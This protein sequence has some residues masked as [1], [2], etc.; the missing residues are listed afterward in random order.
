MVLA[1]SLQQKRR[2]GVLTL[3]PICYDL[4]FTGGI[5]RLP[6]LGQEVFADT[7]HGSLGGGAGITAI[8]LARLGV[9][10]GIISKVGDD[11][12]GHLVLDNVRAEGVDVEHVRVIAGAHTDLSIAISLPSD[13]GFL[14]HVCA[15]RSADVM[16]IPLSYLQSARHLHICL[17]NHDEVA[18][19]A[20]LV[21]TAHLCDLTTSISLGWSDHWHQGLPDVLAM[22]NIV[23]PNVAEALRLC[24][25]RKLERACQLLGRHGATVVITRGAQGAIGWHHGQVI[26]IA[27]EPAEV[28][29]TTGAGD[30]F[31]AG[32]LWASL[33]GYALDQ[34][35][36]VANHCGACSV[37][38]YGSLTTP[39]TPAEL[40]AL[41]AS[42]PDIAHTSVTMDTAPH[43]H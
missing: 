16:D 8:T 12:F 32:F 34:C 40:H 20:W 14:S 18:R 1:A 10:T 25:T 26:D 15:N 23:F 33:Q 36:V 37:A 11:G 24:H 13:R 28:V 29:D 9:P 6:R 43:P 39:P 3:G 17:S 5:N 30:T 27:A 7:L 41:A 42:A 19:W 35:L 2:L 31:A 22:A 38:Q 4:I 21:E